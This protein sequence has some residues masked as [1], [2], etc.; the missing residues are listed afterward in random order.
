MH[1]TINSATFRIYRARA[2]QADGG[3]GGAW[4]LP[5]F[6][7]LFKNSILLENNGDCGFQLSTKAIVT[8][9]RWLINCDQACKNRPSERKNRRFLACLLYH[10]LIPKLYY[11]NKIF[12]ITA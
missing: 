12:I 8:N 2:A 10:N 1:S 6:E 3:A 5:L 9:T 4:A 7:A 11:Y